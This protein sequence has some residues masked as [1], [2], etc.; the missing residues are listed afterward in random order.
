MT[1]K[2]RKLEKLTD[3]E[4]IIVGRDYYDVH[5]ALPRNLK[6]GAS[7]SQVWHKVRNVHP[8]ECD[9]LRISS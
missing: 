1:I 8:G 7:N 3:N 2:K 5:H 6:I 9:A 4:P